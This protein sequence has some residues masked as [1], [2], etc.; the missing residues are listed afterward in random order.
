MHS[1]VGAEEELPEERVQRPKPPARRAGDDVLHQLRPGP[2]P[3]GPPEFAPVGAVA[4]ERLEEERP[5]DVRQAPGV[6]YA[7]DSP[8]SLA[9]SIRPPEVFTVAR[10]EEEQ[11][12]GLG[13]LVVQERAIR[14]LLDEP[15]PG[16]RPVRPPKLLV[17]EEE[18]PPPGPPAEPAG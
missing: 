2:R 9:R 13:H 6:S 5:V 7:L 11:P 14:H 8:G 17:G 18:E 16:A 15:R 3:V 10:R 4:V 12:A 1:V